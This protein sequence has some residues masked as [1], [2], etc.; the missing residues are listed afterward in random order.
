MRGAARLLA[1]GVRFDVIFANPD[2]AKDTEAWEDFRLR[3]REEVQAGRSKLTGVHVGNPYKISTQRTIFEVIHPDP[4]LSLVGP[5]RTRRARAGLL[6]SNDC[7]AVLRLHVDGRPIALLTGDL[8]GA[9]FERIRSSGLEM[10]APVLVFPHH[11]GR[12]GT[13]DDR[14]FAQQLCEAVQPQHVI[15]SH[16]RNSGH[17]TPR[18]EILDGVRQYSKAV[19]VACTQLSLGCHPQSGIPLQRH[20]LP[21]PSAGFGSNSCCAGTIVFRV[22]RNGRLEVDPGYD[23]HSAYVASLAHALCNRL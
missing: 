8:T 14:A 16:G 18:Q 6:T 5:T 20:L 9:S 23:S 12:S 17:G 11:G 22:D 3:V 4:D 7:S 10:R 2:S 19:R 13:V 1:L 15:F 21:R